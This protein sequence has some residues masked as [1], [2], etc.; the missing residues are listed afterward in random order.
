V[1]RFSSRRSL[2]ILVVVAVATA[3]LSETA[4]GA[5]AASS[6]KT[7]A[8]SIHWS[9]VDYQG[10]YEIPA[11]QIQKDFAPYRSSLPTIT[12]E[13]GV[14]DG[15]QSVS[16]A[17]GSIGPFALKAMMC[18]INNSTTPDSFDWVGRVD[19]YKF[20][21]VEPYSGGQLILGWNG[22]PVALKVTA[23][24]KSGYAT[25][26]SFHAGSALVRIMQLGIPSTP[27]PGVGRPITGSGFIGKT[28]VTYTITARAGEVDVP[29][30]TFSATIGHG[31][32][33]GTY[34]VG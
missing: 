2:Q 6:K 17:S 20:H 5:H 4:L 12:V 21:V 14:L 29:N 32:I 8:I 22:K 10:V 30:G 9:Y 33:T 18:Q 19:G 25:G 31:T 3:F 15:C 16:M 7:E 1:I 23:K 28:K 27:Q 11:I 13:D 34:S 24:N 26:F